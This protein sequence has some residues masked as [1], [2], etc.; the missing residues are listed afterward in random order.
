MPQLIIIGA[1][2][3]GRVLLA[4]CRADAGNGKDWTLG[5]FLDDRPDIL[6]GH[7]ANKGDKGI[8][9]S[10]F[11]YIPK[12]GDYFICAQGDP[13]AK[14]KY[15][16]PLIAKKAIFINLCTDINRGDNVG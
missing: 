5:G 13:A 14:R 11:T 4:Q 2:G 15:C 10:P 16:A 8:I 7:Q 1:G 12:P 9:G 6:K 3:F